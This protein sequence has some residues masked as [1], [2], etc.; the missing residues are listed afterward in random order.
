MTSA[1]DFLFPTPT[2]PP[3]LAA[4]ARLS[5]ITPQTVETLKKVLKDNHEHWHI[6]FNDFEFHKYASL[7]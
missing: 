4:P 1:F 7:F 3:N 5:G 2:L 6:F